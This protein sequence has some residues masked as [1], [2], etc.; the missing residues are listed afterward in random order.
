MEVRTAEGNSRY[1][2]AIV[3]GAQEKTCGSIG[4]DGGQVYTVP[5]GNISAVVSNV[6]YD[7]IRPER[8]HLAAHQEVMRQLMS[9][10]TPLPVAFGIITNSVEE[11]RSILARNQAELIDQ[12]GRVDGKVE[13]GLRVLWDVPNIFQYFI[14]THPEL[15]ALRDQVFRSDHGPAHEEKIEVGRLFDNLLRGDRDFHA[16]RVEEVLGQCCFEIKRNEPRGEPEVANLACLVGRHR[17]SEFEAG[18]F[19]AAKLFDNNFAFDYKGPWAPYNFVQV[20]LK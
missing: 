18:V 14:S 7:K 12:L 3:V 4:I 8:R 2:Y 10:T 1:L 5:N 13:M 17:L 19:E 6:H 20:N 15:R 11:V 16:R 9:E